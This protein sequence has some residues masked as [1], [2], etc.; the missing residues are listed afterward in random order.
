MAISSSVFSSSSS[1]FRL[2]NSCDSLLPSAS[3]VHAEHASSAAGEL[4]E[5]SR[6]LDQQQDLAE[7]VADSS[8]RRAEARPLAPGHVRT[9]AAAAAATDIQLQVDAPPEQEQEQGAGDLRVIKNRTW[10]ERGREEKGRRER[11]G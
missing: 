5:H 1:C 9:A 4:E 6:C 10:Q 11:E 7:N 8:S 2:I 3:A